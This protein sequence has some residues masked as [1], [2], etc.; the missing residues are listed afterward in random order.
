VSVSRLSRVGRLAQTRE[1]KREEGG[2]RREERRKKRERGEERREG[3][4]LAA[5][6]LAQTLQ[7]V[8]AATPAA[9][10]DWLYKKGV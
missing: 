2:E 7:R 8:H 9:L 3:E 10:G 6:R 5:G 4:S 1:E